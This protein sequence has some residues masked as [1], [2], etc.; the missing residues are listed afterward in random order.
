MQI[1]EGGLNGWF[2][3]PLNTVVEKTTADM[4]VIASSSLYQQFSE[5]IVTYANRH[6]IKNINAAISRIIEYCLKD[7]E[8]EENTEKDKK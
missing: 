7:Q 6:N 1:L 8:E 5:Q 2:Y 4:T 3:K